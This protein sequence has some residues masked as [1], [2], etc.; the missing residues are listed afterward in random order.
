MVRATTIALVLVL[1]VGCQSSADDYPI[2]VGGTVGPGA[3]SAGAPQDANID[4]LQDG[5]VGDGGIGDAGIGDAGVGDG[6]VAINGRVCLISDLRALGACAASGAGNLQVRLGGASTTTGDDG[7][8]S[9]S[10]PLGANLAWRVTSPRD[11]IVSSV[12]PLVHGNTIP[13]LAVETYNALLNS[14]AV[15][16]SDQQ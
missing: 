7:R 11:T 14:N 6:G 9:I 8:F 12:M 10:A 4:S 13:A 2:N 1:V 16:L 15:L 3:G 5:A